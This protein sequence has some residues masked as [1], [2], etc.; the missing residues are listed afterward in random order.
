MIEI[1]GKNTVVKVDSDGS[2]GDE[3]QIVLVTLNNVHLT[4]NG[5]ANSDLEFTP[6]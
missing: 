4:Q 2:A 6:G 3:G 5:T 1:V